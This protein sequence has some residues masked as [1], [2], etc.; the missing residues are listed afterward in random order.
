MLNEHGFLLRLQTFLLPIISYNVDQPEHESRPMPD[1]HFPLRIFYD[2]A[3]PL[4]SREIEHYRRQDQAGRL[5]PVDISAADFNPE[6]FGI[7]LSAFTFELHAI[8]QAGQIYRGVEAFRVIWQAFPDSTGY[9]TLATLVA[10]PVIN[11]LARFGYRVFARL[12][13]FLP[14]RRA[15][16]AAGT[17]QIGRDS[18]LH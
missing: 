10:L 13:P 17:C 15:A 6:P 2:G 11:P 5:I 1:P 8:D 7:P 12:R 18:H 3:C 9:R 4:C 14:G 16:C